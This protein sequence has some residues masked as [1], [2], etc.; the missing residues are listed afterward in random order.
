MG[1]EGNK[2]HGFLKGLFIGGIIGSIAAVYLSGKEHSGN[3]KSKLGELTEKGKDTFREAVREGKEA[4]ARKEAEI[5]GEAVD[6][7]DKK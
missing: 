7:D 5:R 6:K 4:A 3:L 1:S 2:G